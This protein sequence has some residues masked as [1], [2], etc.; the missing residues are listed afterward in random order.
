M[1]RTPLP[2]LVREIGI[3]A[4]I[5]L[6]VSFNQVGLVIIS[7][8]DTMMSSWLG[9]QALA[10]AGLINSIVLLGQLTV[11]GIL[12]GII[13][14]VGAAAGA[15]KMPLL[16]SAIGSGMALSAILG[17]VLTLALLP[18]FLIIPYLDLS[19]GA[20]SLSS[21]YLLALLPSIV[22]GS[23]LVALR[24]I[25]L[26]VDRIAEVIIVSWLGVI[27]NATA[28]YVL[29]YGKLGAPALGVAGIGVST[30][31]TTAVMLLF[32]FCLVLRSRDSRHLLFG[33]GAPPPERAKL[34]SR[35]L[36]VGWPTGGI[37]C[38]ES[39]AFAASF[40]MMS[41]FGTTA[42][43]AHVIAMQCMSI[44]FLAPMGLSQAIVNRTSRMIGTGSRDGVDTVARA[45]ILLTIGVTLATGLVL[46]LMPDSVAGLI[47]GEAQD[48]DAAAVNTLAAL[49]LRIGA[50]F[51]MAR[52][53]VLAIASFL[54]AC[55]DVRVAF[56]LV[57]FSYWGVGLCTGALLSF[58]FRLGG[59]G[60]WIGLTLGFFYS[61]FQLYWRMKARLNSG[62]ID[63]I[64][65]EVASFHAQRL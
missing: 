59:V 25:L 12:Q 17:L 9:A 63:E 8:T 2:T 5:G 16:R 11:Y 23:L 42:L 41:W 27:I 57:A 48:G 14:V 62:A 31:I 64:I 60:I 1:N 58:G 32:Q 36:A 39:V 40:T 30:S 13:P 52:G 24:I 10:S 35:I 50:A 26:T 38:I 45:A 49:Y 7:A 28:N 22:P 46:L 43:A 29:M 4:G 21:G 61:L 15:D 53:L 18:A 65:Q 55:R 6:S 47:G 51:Q 56:W 3:L 34:L 33:P 19:T 37:I 44:V 20:Q 54:R